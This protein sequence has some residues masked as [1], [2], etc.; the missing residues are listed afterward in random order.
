MYLFVSQDFYYISIC[1][2][3]YHNTNR[4]FLYFKNKTWRVLSPPPHGSEE[5]LGNRDGLRGVESLDH[6]NFIRSGDVLKVSGGTGKRNAYQKKSVGSVEGSYLGADCKD[7]FPNK[8]KDWYIYAMHA[9]MRELVLMVLVLWRELTR[10][11]WVVERSVV[12]WMG[13]CCV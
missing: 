6:F 4:W 12:V 5:G 7:V 11:V 3:V 9:I 1:I 2:Y 13:K 8:S 10:F